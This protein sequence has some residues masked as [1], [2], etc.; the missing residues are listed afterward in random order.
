MKTTRPQ[1]IELQA[2][3]FASFSVTLIFSQSNDSIV[4]V[5]IGPKA[6][7]LYASSS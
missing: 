2:N 7:G 4:A 3:A 1:T 6:P 5:S